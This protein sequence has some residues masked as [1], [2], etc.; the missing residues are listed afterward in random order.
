MSNDLKKEQGNLKVHSLTLLLFSLNS[1]NL[2][3]RCIRTKIPLL[4]G[5]KIR[6]PCSYNHQWLHEKFKLTIIFPKNHQT[7]LSFN[8]Q[9][10]AELGRTKLF[11]TTSAVRALVISPWTWTTPSIG[12]IGCKS[13][14]T[15]SGRS[16]A[17]QI[18]GTLHPWY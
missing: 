11:F 2:I 15:M 14:A 6:D 5:K 4:S 9:I 1:Y 17:L 8:F 12:A 7:K 10:N 13:M 3:S 18:I 16:L